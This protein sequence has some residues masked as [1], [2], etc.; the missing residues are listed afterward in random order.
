M[1]V[2]ILLFSFLFISCGSD[3]EATTTTE[4]RSIFNLWSSTDNTI[5]WDFRNMRMDTLYAIDLLNSAGQTVCTCNGSL[6]GT[7]TSGNYNLNCTSCSDTD[8]NT[9]NITGGSFQSTGARM[10]FCDV[11]SDSSTCATYK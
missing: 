11:P 8:Y 9:I 1:K 7:E 2:I 5:T 3:D 4:A 10:T 6:S